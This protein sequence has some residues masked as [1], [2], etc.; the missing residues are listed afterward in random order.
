M[1]QY[2]FLV[3]GTGLAGLH[4]ALK[5]ANFGKVL[6]ISKSKLEQTNTSYAQGGIAAVTNNESDKA[7][8]IEDTKIAGAGLCDDDIVNIVVKEAKEQIDELVALGTQFDR[9]EDG[10]FHLVKEG[11]HSE[12]RILHY[13][14]QTGFEIQR[15]LTNQVRQNE[16]IDVKEHCFALEIIT[17]HHLGELVTKHREDIECFGA[18]VF[19]TKN[20]KVETILSKVTYM[21]TGGIGFIYQNTTNPENATGDGIAMIYRAKGRIKNMEFVQFHPTALFDIKEKPSFLISEAVRGAGAVLK[22]HAGES[23]MEKYDVR[24][25]LAPRDIVARAIDS[26]MKR[27]GKDFVFLDATGIDKEILENRFP[28]IYN[29]C[30]SQGIDI[31]KDYIPVCPAA[32]Y[33]CGGIQVDSVGRTTIK[34]LYAGGEV[35]C[36]GLH[37]ANRLASN[38][39]LEAAVFANRSAKHVVSEINKITFRKDIPEWDEEG[40]SFPEEMVLITQNWKEMQQIMSNYVGIMRSNLRLHRALVR[41][42][43]IYRET[44]ELYKKTTVSRDICELRNAINVAYL[45]IKMAS[46]RNESI[47]LHYNIDLA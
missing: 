24:G 6:V 33:L 35:A 30:L 16:N 39:L 1:K 19:D 28:T 2:D 7:K 32:H 31:S 46:E 17:Q 45:V 27:S 40:T 34:R 36:T 47:G 9:K 12:K 11:G 10:T 44:E 41:L 29:K 14:D 18:Y 42:E 5:V 21:A 26:E 15:A 8:H 22:N 20:S 25:S 4:F 23:F 38:S 3:I 37:G 13:K 43:I